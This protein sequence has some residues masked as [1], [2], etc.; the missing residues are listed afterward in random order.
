MLIELAV[1]APVLSVSPWALTQTP[2]LTALAVAFALVTYVV[3][4][5][6]VTLTS[7]VFGEADW[8]WPGVSWLAATVNPLPETAVT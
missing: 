8:S 5:E 1:S 7:V 4:P 6:T 2:T 3:S